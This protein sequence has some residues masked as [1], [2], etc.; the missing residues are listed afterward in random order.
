M[1]KKKEA[2]SDSQEMLTMTTDIVASFVA[3]NSIEAEEM[4][5]FIQLVY[6]S[7]SGL[8]ENKHAQLADQKDP[9]VP[10]EESVHSDYL[11][12][13]EDGKKVVVLKRYLRHFYNMTPDEY[14]ARWDLPKDYPMIP[15]NYAK[16]RSAIGKKGNL[17]TYR[18]NRK[19]K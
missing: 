3:K 9:A 17:D 1:T 11:I 7:L 5:N 16:Q 13:L 8:N 14:R 12:C 10:I 19:K 18:S 2:E 15:S 6:S 4:P